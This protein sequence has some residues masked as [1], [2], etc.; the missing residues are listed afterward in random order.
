MEFIVK[1]DLEGS[2]DPAHG[3]HSCWGSGGKGENVEGHK[4]WAEGSRRNLQKTIKVRNGPL[5]SGRRDSTANWP[6]HTEESGQV[7]WKP[8]L[9]LGTVMELSAYLCLGQLGRTPGCP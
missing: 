2:G 5:T 7:R 4:E 1:G 3:P 9:H 6:V 8:P